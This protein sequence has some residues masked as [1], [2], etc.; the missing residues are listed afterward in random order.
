MKKN[1][2]DETNFCFKVI[3]DLISLGIYFAVLLLGK[4]Q[5]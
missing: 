5:L 4:N 3:G 2:T 1:K